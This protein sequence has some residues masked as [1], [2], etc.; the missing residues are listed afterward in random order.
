MVKWKLIVIGIIVF[1]LIFLSTIRAISPR[2]LDDVSPNI[3]CSDELLEKADVYYVIP[4]Y[5]NKSIAENQ[6]WCKNILDY[7]NKTLAMHGV[8]HTYKEFLEDRDE[9]YFQYGAEE[10][11]KCFGYLPNE[12]K[13][14]QL[15]IN[16][17]NKDM[18]E[19]NYKIRTLLAQVT[20]K[21]YHCDDSG[22]FPNWVINII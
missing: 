18:L 5:Q 9:S 22:L 3:P 14:P 16:K 13:P 4:A 10:F 17:N 21:A 6:V 8:I 11:E 19:T 1:L 12:F 7:K 2:Y 20:H 15:A